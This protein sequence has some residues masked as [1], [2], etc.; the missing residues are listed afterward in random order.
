LRETAL[1][2]LALTVAGAVAAACCFGSQQVS[3]SSVTQ[4]CRPY[5]YLPVSNSRGQRFIIRNDNYG[6]WPECMAI[7]D[8]GPDFVVARSG[9][10]SRT[11][12]A[13]FPYIFLGCSWGLCTAPG[14]RTR[15][16]W[17]DRARWYLHSWITHHAGIR[18]R[19]I[20]FRQVRPVWRLS[21]LRLRPFFTALEGRSWIRPWYWLL[22]IEAGFEIWHDGRG[23]ATNWFSARARGGAS[24]RELGRAMSALLQQLTNPPG[25][26]PGLQAKEESGVP[27]SGAGWN[28]YG[29]PPRY[30]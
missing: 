3:A 15:I 21:G 6:G 2:P 28:P 17:I 22:N 7:T 9:A 5:Q 18:W 29:V 12:P 19:L 14:P 20:Q 10:A 1:T 25:G 26:C 4:L 13:A 27:R 30:Y 16:V 24:G 8:G 11:Q 23:L